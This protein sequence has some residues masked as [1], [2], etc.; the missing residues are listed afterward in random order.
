MAW[1]LYLEHDLNCLW[2]TVTVLKSCWD[3]SEPRSPVQETSMLITTP[4]DWVRNT[5]RIC[6]LVFVS[7]RGARETEVGSHETRSGTQ[8][9]SCHHC[10]GNA[11]I[12]QLGSLM[13]NMNWSSC[14]ELN[15]LYHLLFCMKGLQCLVAVTLASIFC[16][17]VATGYKCNKLWYSLTFYCCV[18]EW[19]RNISLS[20]CIYIC[21]MN[22]YN[23]SGI[24]LVTLW[25]KYINGNYLVLV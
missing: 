9:C 15:A 23:C 21:T 3:W 13:W 6:L 10:G 5:S 7:A 24:C 12:V 8:P 25:N 11:N 19:E 14:C 2:D 4:S 18:L 16:Y 22:V 17:R 1:G 20:T